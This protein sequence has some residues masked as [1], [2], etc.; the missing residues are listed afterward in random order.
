MKYRQRN[1]EPILLNYLTHFPVVGLTGPRQSG[2]STLLKHLLKRYT[3]VTFDDHKVITLFYDDPDKFMTIYSDRVIFDEAQKV[4]ELFSYIKMAVDNDRQN[5]GKFILTGSN[6]F[7][8]VK[9]I[10]ESLAGRIGLITLLP[11]SYSE[12]PS[13]L[14]HLSQF[15][16]SYP[17]LVCNHYEFDKE[18]YASYIETYLDKDVRQLHNIGNLREFRLFIT[19]LAANT[20]QLLNKQSYANELGV[21]VPTI[22]RWISILEASY[23]IFLLPPFHNNFGKRITKSPKLYFHDTGLVSYLTGIE[24]EALYKNGPLAG[25]LFENYVISEIKKHLINTNKSYTL[26]FLRTSSGEEIDLIIDKK[27]SQDFIE[28]KRTQTFRPNMTKSLEKYVQEKNQGFLIY[29]GQNVPYIPTIKITSLDL[30][31]KDDCC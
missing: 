7:N 17:E 14:R 16:G 8:L 23:I 27:H 15:K 10:S 20:S 9:T 29:Q 28:I 30:F 12:I 5:Y 13:K 22:S 2:K 11:F 19:R 4:P 24:T 21:S 26:A 31:L 6:Q 3:Y 18:W 1:L 25:A